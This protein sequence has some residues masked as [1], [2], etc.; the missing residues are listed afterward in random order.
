[1]ISAL[2]IENDKENIWHLQRLIAESA[3][4]LAVI[5]ETGEADAAVSLIASHKPDLVFL[6]VKLN[7]GTG[8]DVLDKLMPVN[9][10]VIFTTAYPEYAL[11]AIRYC[12]LDYLLKPVDPDELKTAFERLSS[13]NNPF[14]TNVRLRT[15]FEN[16]G[17]NQ[18]R[19]QRIALPVKEGYEF[20]PAA[21]ITRC[22]T[23]K[24]YTQVVTNSGKK[25]LCSRSLKEYEELLPGDIF[26]RVH[27]SH[28]VNLACIKKFIRDGRGG[29]LLLSD[30]SM[31][32]VALR[33]KDELMRKF[34]S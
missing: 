17:N 6:D 15:L 1:M 33:R 31:V 5:G 4:P 27:H 32:E 11:K 2:I 20:V 34:G 25:Y 3:L 16:L 29:Y 30:G 10:S 23:D 26:F 22:T 28:L 13:L 24:N 12:A 18:T 7:G 21:D 19:L 14:Y 9:F 8:F